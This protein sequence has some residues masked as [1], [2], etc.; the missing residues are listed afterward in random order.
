LAGEKMIKVCIFSNYWII[1]EGVKNIL[2]RTYDMRIVTEATDINSAKH[3]IHSST[4][5]VMILDF[6]SH[7]HSN[8]LI[9][10]NLHSISPQLPILVLSQ[11]D[12]ELYGYICLLAGAAGYLTV[13]C[14]ESD[15]IHAIQKLA[16]GVRYFKP[17]TLTKLAERKE[18]Q[19]HISLHEQLSA[20]ELQILNLIGVGRTYR[21]IAEELGINHKTV[22]TYRQRILIKMQMNSNAELMN[23]VIKRGLIS[24]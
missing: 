11:Y 5:D 15:L 10:K 19:G 3:I 6:S 21:Q 22:T 7:T 20:R 18:K 23:Y 2:E 14:S 9:I 24:W 17:A 12:E 13:N 1:C 8:V 4:V 16:L